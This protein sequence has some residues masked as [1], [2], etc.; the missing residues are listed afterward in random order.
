M[1][2]EELDKECRYKSKAW[3]DPIRSYIKWDMDSWGYFNFD[4]GL[5]VRT[6]LSDTNMNADD[7]YKVYEDGIS[8]E[9][10]SMSKMLAKAVA[11]DYKNKGQSRWYN[12][13]LTDGNKAFIHSD[14]YDDIVELYDV[15]EIWVSLDGPR[16]YRCVYDKPPKEE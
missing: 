7:Y 12:D 10:P 8:L 6:V 13:V 2:I 11:P 15:S 4:G 9:H 1:K 5:L 14:F 3:R 16:A